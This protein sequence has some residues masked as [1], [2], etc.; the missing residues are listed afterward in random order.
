[1]PSLILEELGIRI[2]QLYLKQ[3]IPIYS[4]TCDFFTK[5]HFM[6]RF[7]HFLLKGHEQPPKTI[8]LLSPSTVT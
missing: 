7:L 3:I 8:Q 2:T 1:M 5:S 4:N 6:L